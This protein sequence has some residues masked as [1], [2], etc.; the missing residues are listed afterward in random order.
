VST[1][2]YFRFDDPGAP[3]LSGTVGSLTNLLR[4]CLVGTNGVAY[5]GKPSAGWTEAFI[6]AA[7]NIAVF[8]NNQAEGFSGCW[9]RINDNAPGTGGAREAYLNV[10]ASMTDVDTGQQGTRTYYA[11]KSASADTTP[12]NWMLVA[13]GGTA[14]LYTWATG[15]Y[16]G[17]GV[18]GN[19]I[20]FGDYESIAAT[21][22]YRYCASGRGY[23][24][25][26][27][28][29]GCPEVF[30]FVYTNG[31]MN[32][33]NSM[34]IGPV[35][36]VGDVLSARLVMP[37]LGYSTSSTVGSSGWPSAPNAAGNR[38]FMD[39]PFIYSQAGLAGRMR[40]LHVP[41]EQLYAEPHGALVPGSTN[42]RVVRANYG[43]NWD[44]SSHAALALDCGGPW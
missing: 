14:W 19:I 30:A 25:Y 15:D 39:G 21:G 16:A 8:R 40:G 34:Q 4:T 5:G 36:G 1:V 31:R 42:L 32:I 20:L 12:R 43:G 41:F 9:V 44:D 37:H 7:P 6:G 33:S 18:D 2:R 11:R 23:E 10:Y 26:S 22:A 13:D 24:G 29:D 28:G 27:S 38:G 3:Q 35:T 17:Y